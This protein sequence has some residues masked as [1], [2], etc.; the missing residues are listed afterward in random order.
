MCEA[1]KVGECDY[2]GDDIFEGDKIIRIGSDI[3][4]AGCCEEDTAHYDDGEGDNADREY[5]ERVAFEQNVNLLSVEMG[6][7][8]TDEM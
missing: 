5:D 3:Y 4:H 2:C 7:G 8:D 6:E 1:R